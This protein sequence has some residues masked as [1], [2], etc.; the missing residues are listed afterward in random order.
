LIGILFD[1]GLVAEF[2]MKQADGIAEGQL[3]CDQNFAG[4]D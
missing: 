3:S 2:K 1:L 4:Q